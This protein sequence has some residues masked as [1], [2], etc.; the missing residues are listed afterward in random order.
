[1]IS[2]CTSPEHW[3][4]PL[5]LVNSGVIEQGAGR[6]GSLF[7]SA[8]TLSRLRFA[9]AERIRRPLGMFFDTTDIVARWLAR[10]YPYD[11]PW[12]GLVMFQACKRRSSWNS[13]CK[14]RAFR[15]GFMTCS[16]FMQSERFSIVSTPGHPTHS[17]VCINLAA[18]KREAE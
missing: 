4:N 12:L 17:R 16:T 13:T 8:T 11:L 15:P 2:V 5:H 3:L 7:R 1:M 14:P 10:L 18:S 9:S 6:A